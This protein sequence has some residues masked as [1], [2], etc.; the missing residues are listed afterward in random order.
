MFELT[1]EGLDEAIKHLISGKVFAKSC[2]KGYA[3]LLK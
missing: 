3:F 2:V 1:L